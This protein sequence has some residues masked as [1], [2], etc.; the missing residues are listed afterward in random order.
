MFDEKP[1]ISKHMGFNRVVLNAPKQGAYG[2]VVDSKGIFICAEQPGIFHHVTCPHAGSGTVSV[3]DGKVDWKTGQMIGEYGEP[4]PLMILHPA[5]MGVWH[6]SCGFN[7]GLIVKSMGDNTS[8]TPSLFTPVWNVKKDNFPARKSEYVESSR[9]LTTADCILY[10]IQPNG[11]HNGTVRVFDGLN[12]LLWVMPSVFKG[13]FVVEH[14]DAVGGLRV[15]LS[16]DPC[17]SVT[18][19][20]QE[21][22]LTPSPN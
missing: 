13:S 11:A 16:G 12:R 20:W 17:P 5:S 9:V 14:I 8:N 10:S 3:L 19:V 2:F 6:L 18:V 7:V 4:R 21:P 1:Y 15:E 22:L